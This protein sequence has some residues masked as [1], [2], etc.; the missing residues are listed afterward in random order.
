MYTHAAP[1]YICPFCLLV[2]GK[3][4]NQTQLKQTDI[5]FQTADVTAFMATQKWPNNQGHVLIIPNEHF[6]NIFDLPLYLS[7]EIHALSRNIAL[8]MKSEYQCDG[9]MLRQHN[10]PAGDQNIFHYHLHVAKTM[11]FI[12]HRKAHLLPRIAPNMLSS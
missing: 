12:V 4:N 11:I 10:E 7:S 9:I 3:E 5:V 6:E 8:T 1:G 2:K